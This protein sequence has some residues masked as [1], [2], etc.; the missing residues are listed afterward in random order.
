MCN[1]CVVCSVS[2]VYFA[3]QSGVCGCSVHNVVCHMSVAIESSVHCFSVECAL[4]RFGSSSL[5]CLLCGVQ[6]V[7]CLVLYVLCFMFG[8]LCI[9]YSTVA[10]FRVGSSSLCCLLVKLEKTV[11]TGQ[12]TTSPVMMMMVTIMMVVNDWQ[13]GV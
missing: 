11:R 8:E 7:L 1:M 5:C 10:V 6:C 9:V 13:I 3:L 12:A 4:R 2:K